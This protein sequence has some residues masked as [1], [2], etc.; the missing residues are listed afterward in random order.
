[1]NIV[2]LFAVLLFFA[3]GRKMMK[4]LVSSI[5]FSF[6]V[7]VS[8]AVL[9]DG[10]E[11]TKSNNDFATTKMKLVEAIKAKSFGIVAEVDHAA[12]ATSAGLVLR[13][14][15]LVI[16]GNPKGG[17]PLMGCAQEAGLDLPLK[18]LVWQAA[19]GAVNVSINTASYIAARHKIA[20]CAEAPLGN[21]G[22]TLEAIVADAI[23][24]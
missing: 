10:V 12:G 23:K 4:I 20:A 11:T 17:T 1:V 24:R 2:L 13:P 16:F 8:T 15:H 14:T 6:A 19:D 21:M 18:A 3:T 22:K 5:A 7:L 9:A